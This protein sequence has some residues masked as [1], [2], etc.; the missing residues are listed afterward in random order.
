LKNR[1]DVLLMVGTT[2][3]EQY[4]RFFERFVWNRDSLFAAGRNRRKIVFLGEVNRVPGGSR[5][6]AP[7]PSVIRCTRSEIPELLA[8]LRAQFRGTALQPGHPLTRRRITAL[9]RLCETLK[10]A[11]YGVVV[12]SAAELEPDSAEVVV[13]AL[14]D[15][16]TELNASTRFAGLSLSGNDGGMTFQ[17]VCAWQN[18]FPLRVGYATGA[19]VYEPVLNGTSTLLRNDAADALLWL[20]SMNAD[21]RPPACGVPVIAV[22][23]PSRR[24]AREAEVFIPVATPGLDHAGVLFR[25]DS[26]VSLPLRALRRAAAPAAADVL[27]AIMRRL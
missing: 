3:M 2:A 1:A 26:V 24:L 21:L 5:R 22:A 19:P 27:T 9:G 23:R 15:L 8:A 20:N 25:T 12:W 14:C 6:G 16:I 10:A 13:R 7:R 18:G 17:N 11:R 4:P